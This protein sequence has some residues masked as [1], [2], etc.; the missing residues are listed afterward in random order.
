[1]SWLKLLGLAWPFIKE[2]LF[3][4]FNLWGYLRRNKLTGLLLGVNVVIFLMF[5]YI[6]EQT[7]KH[8]RDAIVAHQAY[9]DEHR[10]RLLGEQRYGLI[11]LPLPLCPTPSIPRHPTIVH[12]FIRPEDRSHKRQLHPT[13]T[14]EPDRSRLIHSL[15]ELEAI[16]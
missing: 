5:I 11:T 2:I 7:F 4:K 16:Q 9:L 3:G 14:T 12:P 15:T 1:M 13:P 8:Q 6:S 10:L